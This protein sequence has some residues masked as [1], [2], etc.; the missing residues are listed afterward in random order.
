MI[1]KKRISVYPTDLKFIKGHCGSEGVA[2]A[3]TMI[4]NE[5]LAVWNSLMIVS[6][7]QYSE[8]DL[9][10]ALEKTER[11]LQDLQARMETALLDVTALIFT[12]QI[13]MLKDK[14]FTDSIFILVRKGVNPP[15]AIVGSC[16]S[17]C[18]NS[19]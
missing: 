10:R 6:G 11:Q 9:Q 15:R 8:T 1:K 4:I 18:L 19:A 16:A 5:S 13:L 7:S 17:M 14:G 12:A 3:T 2:C